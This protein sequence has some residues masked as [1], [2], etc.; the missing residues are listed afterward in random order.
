MTHWRKRNSY[1][2]SLDDPHGVLT[3]DR[4][5]AVICAVLGFVSFVCLFFGSV[6]LILA[7]QL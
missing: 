6:Y 5:F 1:P 2:R 4:E 3:D 7:T